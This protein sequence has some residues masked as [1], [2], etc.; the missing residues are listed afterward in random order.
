MTS[1]EA[2]VAMLGLARLT[3]VPLLAVPAEA[4]WPLPVWV[5]PATWTVCV[6]GVPGCWSTEGIRR[7]SKVK[8]IRQLLPAPGSTHVL[9]ARGGE[10][11]LAVRWGRSRRR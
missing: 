10:A 1:G 9:A 4:D 2:V 11:D 3:V 5:L 7:T 8:S 6:P